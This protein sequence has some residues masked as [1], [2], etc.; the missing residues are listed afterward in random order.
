ML[1]TKY[2]YTVEDQGSDVVVFITRLL[3]KAVKTFRITNKT[4]VQR[5][6]EHMNSLTDELVDNFFPKE[7]KK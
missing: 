3:D 1:M 2:S 6:C 4:T 7:R 5:M